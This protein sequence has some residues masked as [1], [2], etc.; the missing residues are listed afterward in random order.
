VLTNQSDGT[1]ESAVKKVDLSEFRLANGDTP[2][3]LTVTSMNWDVRGF[4][5]V[6]LEWDHATNEVIGVLSGQGHTNFGGVGL[7]DPKDSGDVS[8]DIVLTTDGA[9]DGDAYQIELHL[10]LEN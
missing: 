5:Y 6:T 3:R 4:N 8:G 2:V 7:Q 1:G 10:K 9:A